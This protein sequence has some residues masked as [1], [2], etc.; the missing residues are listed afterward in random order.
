MT[1]RSSRPL[2]GFVEPV[3][4]WQVVRESRAAGR[5]DA[6][7]G[8]NLGALLDVKDRWAVELAAM[9]AS[10]ASLDEISGQLE[11]IS[12]AASGVRRSRPRFCPGRSRPDSQATSQFPPA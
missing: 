6:L 8:K 2:K 1:R 11:P 5:F 12:P 7:H 10:A 9:V 3:Q 4:L